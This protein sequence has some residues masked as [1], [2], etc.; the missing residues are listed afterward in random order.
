MSRP[1][2]PAS[3]SSRSAS[4]IAARRI[5]AAVTAE[6]DGTRSGNGEEARES[7]AEAVTADSYPQFKEAVLEL[8]RQAPEQDRVSNL[9][10]FC[11]QVAQRVGKA[12]SAARLADEAKVTGLER[13]EAA[14]WDGLIENWEICGP[15]RFREHDTVFPPEREYLAKP[16]E[17]ALQIA[18]V[19]NATDPKQSL[20]I[21]RVG[22]VLGLSAGE[23][24]GQVAYARTTI[25]N[26]AARSATFCLGSGGWVKVWVNGELVHESS[27]DRACALDQDRFTVSL[28]KGPNPVLI[29]EGNNSGEWNFCLRLA[30][31]SETLA[32]AK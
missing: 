11:Q 27:N 5:I 28:K 18:T 2:S 13:A 22:K 6:A 8:V 15:Y 25:T 19:W 16:G 4:A 1:V 12:E 23:T 32:S 21:V 26:A 31:A 24:I 10:G 9:I 14:A 17:A 29:K 30:E 20:G 7:L 3:S